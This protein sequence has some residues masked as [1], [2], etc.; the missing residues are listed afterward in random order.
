VAPLPKR[1]TVVKESY[2]ESNDGTTTGKEH[3]S[4]RKEKRQT[5][6]ERL[7]RDQSRRARLGDSDCSN[8]EQVSE[9]KDKKAHRSERDRKHGR[10][11]ER[12]DKERYRRIE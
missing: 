9:K 12:R 8:A 1:R 10:Q 4:D 2:Y 6:I 11:Q 7:R 5:Q 3:R